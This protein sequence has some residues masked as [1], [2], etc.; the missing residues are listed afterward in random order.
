VSAQP[1]CRD[2]DDPTHR[3][4]SIETKSESAASRM[5]LPLDGLRV[6]VADDSPDNQKL[7]SF[8]LRRSGAL[9][10][11]AENGQITC[12][13]ALEAHARNEPFDVIVMDMQMPVLDGYLA[14]AQL[15]RQEYEFPVIAL[16]AHSMP[17]D[18]QKCLDAGCDAHLTKPIDRAEL[19]EAVGRWC[20]QKRAVHDDAMLCVNG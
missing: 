17:G 5:P 6:L 4:S 16:T 3:D 13:L 9:V 7:V 11:T 12:D 1:A 18:R 10:T 8:V 15:R 2:G 14:T 20:S 19:V